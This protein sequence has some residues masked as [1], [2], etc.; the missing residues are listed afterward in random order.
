MVDYSRVL[1]ALPTAQRVLSVVPGAHMVGLGTKITNGQHSD[2]PALMVFV[3]H[4]RPLAELEPSHIVPNTI[5]GV[6]TDVVQAAPPQRLSGPDESNY[7]TI[8]GGIQILP[9]GLTEGRTTETAGAFPRVIPGY[10]I[11]GLGTLGFFVN[12]NNLQPSVHA[13]T[14]WHV[15]GEPMRGSPTNIKPMRGPNQHAWLI[16]ADPTTAITV[17]TLFVAEIT[18]VYNHA[19]TNLAAFYRSSEGETVS[20]VVN[21]L[22]TAINSTGHDLNA[23]SEQ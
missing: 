23:T 15:V 21:A 11:G 13:V 22:V 17:D 18:V 10:G 2:E 16:D 12:V 3:R 6:L 19:L 4:K 14:N 7:K 9:G 5:E 8:R 20:G 1:A